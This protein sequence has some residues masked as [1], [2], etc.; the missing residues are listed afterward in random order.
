MKFVGG[1]KIP[2]ITPFL[3]A[4]EFHYLVAIIL[5][6]QCRIGDMDYWFKLWTSF[7]T[8]A[9][10]MWVKAHALVMKSSSIL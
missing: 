2:K 6:W 1:N 4:H 9:K 3:P 7:Y 10:L 8:L 5:N